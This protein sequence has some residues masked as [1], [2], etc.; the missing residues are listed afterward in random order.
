MKNNGVNNLTNRYVFIADANCG[1]SAAGNMSVDKNGYTY[2][3]DYEN[4][5]RNPVLSHVA[6]DETGVDFILDK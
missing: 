4:R 3:Y 5:S 6:F 1:Y 2:D